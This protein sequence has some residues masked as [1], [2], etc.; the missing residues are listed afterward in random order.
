MMNTDA[1]ISHAQTVPFT[2]SKMPCRGKHFA[3]HVFSREGDA[4]DRPAIEALICRVFL[5]EN[6]LKGLVGCRCGSVR[7]REKGIV[8]A[9]PRRGYPLRFTGA[10]RV[11]DHNAHAMPSVVIVEIALPVKRAPIRSHSGNNPRTRRGKLE[12]TH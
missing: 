11:L 12:S 9:E 3:E 1:G 7:L 4:V 6:H 2:L 8:P 5:R 10:A